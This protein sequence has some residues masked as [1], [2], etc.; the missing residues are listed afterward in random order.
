MRDYPLMTG[1]GCAKCPVKPCQT[2]HYRGSTCAAQRAKCGLGDPMTWV[3]KIRGESDEYLA[4]QLV[5]FF[6]GGIR[7]FCEMM[8]LGEMPP[9]EDATFEKMV[10]KQLEGLHEPYDF[11]SDQIPYEHLNPKSA[12]AQKS[13]LRFP[14]RL[15]EVGQTVYW[16]ADRLRGVRPVKIIG[17]HI[18]ANGYD[19]YECIGEGYTPVELLAANFGATW[20]TDIEKANA[21]HD[22]LK[23]QKSPEVAPAISAKKEE[24]KDA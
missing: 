9:I 14:I 16:C 6:L 18:G 10:A 20:F 22:E 23:T 19:C 3:D 24:T 5:I 2:S 7:S 15:C 4:R 17:I 8:E 21:R 11:K 12:S 13:E 1:G